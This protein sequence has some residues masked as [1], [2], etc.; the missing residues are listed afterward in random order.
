LLPTAFND[1]KKQRFRWAFGGMQILRRNWRQLIPSP[2]VGQEMEL[3][4]QQRMSYT[5]GL[6]GWLND[7]LFLVF[8]GFLLLTAAAFVNGW[9]LPVR[10]LA[11]WIL[12]VPLLSITTGV[13]RVAWALRVTTKCSW[14]DGIGAFSSM[15]S[16][17]WTVARACA[18][19]IWSAEGSFLRTP[20]FEVES[21]LTRALRATTWETILG[22][23]LLT[24]VPLVLNTQT[25]FEGILLAAL[26]V[27]HA[28]VYLSALRASLIEAYPVES[29][30]LPDSP[31][32]AAA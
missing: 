9:Q 5:M 2:L 29:D 7:L 14:R 3:A 18:A 12:L 31:N 30:L 17:S 1:T 15:L 27:W 26:L 11:E 21:D 28:L 6:L 8:T 10:Q 24:A 23:V 19:A 16:L 25:S 13:L 22:I 20:K 32:S 4:F